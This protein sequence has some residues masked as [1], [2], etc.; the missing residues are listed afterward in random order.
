M[1]D[2]RYRG[3]FPY[4]RMNLRPTFGT[5]S[6]GL[7]FMNAS[8]HPSE[9]DTRPCPRCRNTLVF[10]NH[11][12]VLLVGTAPGRSASEAGMRIRYEP[13]WVCR[14]GC[15]DYREIVRDA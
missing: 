15:C 12:P 14:N 1:H 2:R 4:D 5:Y 13:A 8:S 10:K 6:R 3:T 7:L 11:Y 9:D